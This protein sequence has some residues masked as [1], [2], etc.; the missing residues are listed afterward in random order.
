MQCNLSFLLPVLV[1]LIFGLER[2]SFVEEAVQRQR[3]V[4]KAG[5]NPPT[6]EPET[7]YLPTAIP[8]VREP[9]LPRGNG[10]VQVGLGTRDL[11]QT[12][13]DIPLAHL[14]RYLGCCSL[15]N[16]YGFRALLEPQNLMNQF[17]LD[18]EK[19]MVSDGHWYPI[20]K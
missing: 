16:L 20:S 1:D 18:R 8:V 15:T 12:Q 17:T 4:G 9:T 7:D 10:A 13:Q 2:S 14:H 19:P 6:V 5:Y 11:I 3:Q